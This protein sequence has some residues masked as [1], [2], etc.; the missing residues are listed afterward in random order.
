M[1]KNKLKNTLKDKLKNFKTKVKDTVEFIPKNI[2]LILLIAILIGILINFIDPIKLYIPYDF[3][4][5][6]NKGITLMFWNWALAPFNKKQS[7]A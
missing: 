5:F 4:V 2:P 3:K 7:L 1:K 6:L